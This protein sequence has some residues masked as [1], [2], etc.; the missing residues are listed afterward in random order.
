MCACVVA[1]AVG[2]IGCSSDAALDV[3]PNESTSTTSAALTPEAPND[4]YIL[5]GIVGAGSGCVGLGSVIPTI[6]PDRKSFTVA[7][8]EMQLEYPPAPALKSKNCAVTMNIHVP[9]GWQFSIATI[10]TRGYANFPAPVSARQI[11]SYFFAGVPL[12]LQAHSTISG[13]TDP[14]GELYTFTDYVG[15]SS[16]VWSPC[17]ATRPFTINSRIVMD[18]R[19]APADTEAIFSND[20]VDG[21]FHKVFN[22]QWRTCP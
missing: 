5:D 15:F 1:L 14:L 11:S 21:E 8:T 18:A 4:V 19:Q 22:W 20:T 7:F 9:H 17:G 3:N 12:G 6:A 2:F 10:D 13:P 16:L